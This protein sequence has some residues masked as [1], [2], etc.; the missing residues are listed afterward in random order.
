MQKKYLSVLIKRIKRCRNNCIKDDREYCKILFKSNN[1][2]RAKY[3]FMQRREKV[4]NLF[5]Q[6]KNEKR[7]NLRFSIRFPYR[8]EIRNKFCDKGCRTIV[9][10]C[11]K[12]IN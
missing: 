8:Y 12:K 7:Y 11:L 1:I 3:S 2:K 4:Y 6:K 5:I 9:R 10:Y